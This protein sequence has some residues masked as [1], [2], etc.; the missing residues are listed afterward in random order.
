MA[1]PRDTLSGS[2]TQFS[3]LNSISPLLE[4]I[5]VGLACTAGPGWVSRAAF[6]DLVVGCELAGRDELPPGVTSQI[7]LDFLREQV[8]FGARAAV[9]CCQF[10]V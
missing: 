1:D 8:R 10:R 2:R 6:V 3:P 7:G 9:A 4:D 5:S